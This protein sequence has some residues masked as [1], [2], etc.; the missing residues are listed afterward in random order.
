MQP[1]FIFSRANTGLTPAPKT[2][3]PRRLLAGADRHATNNKPGT[4]PGLVAGADRGSPH[5]GDSATIEVK[6]RRLDHL[7]LRLADALAD[8]IQLEERIP[9]K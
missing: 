7:A 2:A 4:W 6:D 8:T 5:I 3:S 1:L 9:Q